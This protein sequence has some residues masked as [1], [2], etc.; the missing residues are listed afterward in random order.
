MDCHC[1]QKGAEWLND[2]ITKEIIDHII[3]LFHL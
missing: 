1:L 3:L 2:V